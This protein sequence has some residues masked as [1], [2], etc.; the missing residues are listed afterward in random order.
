MTKISKTTRDKLYKHLKDFRKALENYEENHEKAMQKKLYAKM[1]E[2]N[3]ELTKTLL[4]E[5]I[6]INLQIQILSGKKVPLMY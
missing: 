1:D 3:R 6:F 2:R 5:S 4:V